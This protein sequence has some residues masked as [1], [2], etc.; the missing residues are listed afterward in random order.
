MAIITSRDG[1]APVRITVQGG[2]TI[3]EAAEF[4]AHLLAALDTGA[5]L[6]LDLGEVDEADSAGVQLMLLARREA[7][8]TGVALHV[9]RL[10]PA[11]D[12][13]LDRWGLRAAFAAAPLH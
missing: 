7:A 2:M 1:N 11:V 8:R 10:A 5:A 3:Y 6:E 9:A 13:A 12:E 4:K